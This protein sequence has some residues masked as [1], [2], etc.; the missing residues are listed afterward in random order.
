MD[1]MTIPE[2]ITELH[3][4]AGVLGEGTE[5]L[6]LNMAADVIEEQDERISILADIMVGIEAQ[7]DALNAMLEGGETDAEPGDGEDGQEPA[8]EAV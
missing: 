6:L 4:Q 5:K 2:L 7:I 8:D 3:D 1:K